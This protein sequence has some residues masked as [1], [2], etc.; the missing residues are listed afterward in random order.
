MGPDEGMIEWSGTFLADAL[1]ATDPALRAQQLDQ[2]RAAGNPLPLVWGQFYYTVLISDFTA[3][4]RYSMVPYRI[5]CLVLRNEATSPPEDASSSDLTSATTSDMGSALDVAPA[6][7]QATLET[8]QSSLAAIGTIS[9]AGTSTVTA[10]AAVTQASDTLETM[11][12]S[13]EASVN[14]IVANAGT[15]LVGSATDL[16]NAVAATAELAQ[17]TAAQGYVG[18]MSVNLGG[19]PWQ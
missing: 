5:S 15:S 2:M 3:D 11:R 12:E 14:T 10:L 4:T 7:A 9:P 13:T 19:A 16:T 6:D 17:L 18:R 8:T 1:D